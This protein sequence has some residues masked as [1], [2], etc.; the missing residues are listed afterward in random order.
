MSYFGF[1][2]YKEAAAR[3]KPLVEAQPDNTELAYLLAKCYL[4]SGEGDEGMA[5][6][7]KL[8]ERDPDSAAVHMLMGEAFDSR[9]KTE[10]AIKEFEIAAKNEPVQPDVHFGSGLSLLEEKRYDDAEREF[11]LELKNNPSQNKAIVYLGDVE[12]KAGR[13]ADALALLKKA[14]GLAKDSHLAHLDMAIIDQQEKQNE[15]A[16]G[17]FRE[18][19]RATRAVMMRITVWRGCLKEMGQQGRGGAGIRDCAE[20]A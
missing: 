8:L 9:Q 16:V 19:I 10:E 11:D 14:V 15:L 1:G 20:A 12:M 17:E 7:Q 2:Q 5:L 13:N 4:W 3:F 6:F 18:A